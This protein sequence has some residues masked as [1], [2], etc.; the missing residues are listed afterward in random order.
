[1]RT[2]I[3]LSCW[4]Y[5]VDVQDLQVIFTESRPVSGCK[6]TQFSFDRPRDIN[7]SNGIWYLKSLEAP[8]KG[9][10]ASH[11]EEA[12]NYCRKQFGASFADYTG[13]LASKT[14]NTQPIK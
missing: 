4:G 10:P 11:I 14:K 5:F 1:M 13:E 7:N 8:D 6:V 3:T 2:E 9:I 12:L